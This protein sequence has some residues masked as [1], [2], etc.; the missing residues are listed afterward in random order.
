MDIKKTFTIDERRYAKRGVRRFTRKEVQARYR[1]NWKEKILQKSKEYKRKKRLALGIIP[2]QP[3]QL[4]LP[5]KACKKPAI[6]RKERY[7]AD[8]EY[9]SAIIARTG[10]RARDKR[11][12]VNAYKSRWKLAKRLQDPIFDMTMRLRARIWMAF[13]LKKWTKKASAHVLLGADYKT[14][15]AHIES[16]FKNGMTWENRCQWHID[17][18]IPLASAKSIEELLPLFN[19][20]NL[21]PLWAKEN[22]SK[23]AKCPT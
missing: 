17:H 6:S 18:I 1:G 14:V 12:E 22:M 2:R 23:G 21:Q 9:R 5:L 20:T 4:K 16:L 3:K 11:V 19:Y 10:K 8:P 7:R 15:S 13:R